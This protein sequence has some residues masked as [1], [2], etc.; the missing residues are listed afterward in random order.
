MKHLI[1]LESLKL[2]T[3]ILMYIAL[4]LTVISLVDYLWRNRDVMKEK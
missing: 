1:D 3:D 2:V 4:A